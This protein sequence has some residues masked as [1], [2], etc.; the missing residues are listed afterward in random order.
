MAHDVAVVLFFGESDPEQVGLAHYGGPSVHEVKR[1]AKD[2]AKKD[3]PSWAQRK[4]DCL[5]EAVNSG[6]PCP[7]IWRNARA[8]YWP[9]CTELVPGEPGFP[10]VP[11]AKQ[12]KPQLEP[13]PEI[14]PIVRIQ[15]GTM[16][17]VPEIVPKSNGY[18]IAYAFFSPGGEPLSGHFMARTKRDVF[19]AVFDPTNDAI[20]DP[21]NQSVFIDRQNWEIH[22]RK[23]PV[24]PTKEQLFR[25]TLPM[26]S[27]VAVEKYQAL[28]AAHEAAKAELDR[29]PTEQEIQNVGLTQEM[30]DRM[31]G[32]V[33]RDRM[34]ADKAFRIAVDRFMVAQEKIREKEQKERDAE[35]K[36]AQEKAAVAAAKDRQRRREAGENVDDPYDRSRTS[37][38]PT[39]R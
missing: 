35:A 5:R 2:R 37:H 14:P 32:A 22:S 38:V 34:L 19:D 25:L 17:V 33:L 12:A 6:R 1:C 4:A 21:D 36:A 20:P 13:I 15:D 26:A 11:P 3:Q 31:P 7:A 24:P 8:V 16:R 10:Y 9:E 39:A 23:V 29:E 30:L 27:T 28:L 18:G